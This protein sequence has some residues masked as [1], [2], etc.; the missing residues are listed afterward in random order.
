MKNRQKD[1]YEKKLLRFMKEYDNLWE[2]SKDSNG[3]VNV[4]KWRQL[5]DNLEKQ[6]GMTHSSIRAS[7]NKR[8][9]TAQNATESVHNIQ[10]KC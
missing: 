7:K 3:F 6:Y 5:S 10:M 1:R 2:K 4:E 8:P 9:T